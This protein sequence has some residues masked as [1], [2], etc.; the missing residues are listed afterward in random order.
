MLTDSILC[1]FILY[2]LC[3]LLKSYLNIDGTIASYDDSRML[4]PSPSI[5]VGIGL[6]RDRTPNQALPSREPS[7]SQPLNRMS[8]SRATGAPM[9][10]S[11][12][13][14]N[15]FSSLVGSFSLSLSFFTFNANFSASITSGA[16]K[17]IDD[18]RP[19][20]QLPSRPRTSS[21]LRQSKTVTKRAHVPSAGCNRFSANNN[22]AEEDDEEAAERRNAELVAVA[23]TSVFKVPEGFKFGG[24]IT[25]V[26]CSIVLI[27]VRI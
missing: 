14:A 26:R 24:G 17:V 19:A 13:A 22:N 10:A 4:S 7:V 18:F 9:R 3:Y 15:P 8:I 23:T 25:P 11:L 5:S 20:S 6:G 2:F 1:E 27:F 16:L 21:S 12:S